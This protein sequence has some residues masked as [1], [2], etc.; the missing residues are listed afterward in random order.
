MHTKR[1]SLLRDIP[2]LASGIVAPTYPP[3]IAGWLA[4]IHDAVKGIVY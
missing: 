3:G 1:V 2:S 4:R